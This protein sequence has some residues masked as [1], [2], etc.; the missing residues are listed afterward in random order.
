MRFAQKVIAAFALSSI[1]TYANPVGIQAAGPVPRREAALG[2]GDSDLQVGAPRLCAGFTSAGCIAHCKSLGYKS[3]ACQGTY[4][5]FNTFIT[6]SDSQVFDC[7][8][9]FCVSFLTRLA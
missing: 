7:R 4:V 2:S 8:T 5:N 1:Y 3:G 9:C 6:D